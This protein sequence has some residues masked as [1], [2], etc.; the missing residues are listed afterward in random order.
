MPVNPIRCTMVRTNTELERPQIITFHIG[1]RV[2]GLV[3]KK[4]ATLLVYEGGGRKVYSFRLQNFKKGL[5]NLEWGKKQ[6]QF[7][8]MQK[9][10]HVGL[11]REML[12]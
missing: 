7:P 1:R 5:E 4:G 11:V 9:R 10:R 2:R 12:E 3:C 6:S 8:R